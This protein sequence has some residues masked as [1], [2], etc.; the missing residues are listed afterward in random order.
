MKYRDFPGG[1]TVDPARESLSVSQSSKTSR[2][3]AKAQRKRSD[4]K[5][6]LA[7]REVLI[8][9]IFRRDSAPFFAPS[10]LCEMF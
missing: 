4:A 2:K 8:A 5:Q 9:G 10:R 7:R 3:G 6:G 1:F